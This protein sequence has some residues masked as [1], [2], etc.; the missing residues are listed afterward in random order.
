MLELKCFDDIEKLVMGSA[1]LAGGGGG[2]V[3]EG[4]K[5]GKLA[6]EMGGVKILSIEE[7]PENCKAV[8]IATVGSQIMGRGVVYAVDYNKSVIELLSAVDSKIGV[9]P[10]EVGGL[11]SICPFIPA[12]SL[13]IPVIDAPC[14]GR[15]HPTVL[16]GS[17]GLNRVKS[18]IS[19]QAYS[20]RS[21]AVYG[22]V[23]GSL[24]E[25]SKI[26]RIIASE[27]GAVAVARNPV[28]LEYLKEK[29]APGA[30]EQAYKIGE[31]FI[32]SM[33]NPLE[34]TYRIADLMSG[35]VIE[36]V[37]LNSVKIT[38]KKGFDVGFAK[39][40][41]SEHKIE[42]S[43]IN[44][45]VTLEVDGIRKATFPDL[46]TMIDASNGNP[47]LSMDL[48]RGLKVHIVIVDRKKLKLGYGL[49]VKESYDIIEVLLG[50]KILDYIRDVFIR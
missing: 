42:V 50:K 29:G 40:V 24:S 14:D 25:A 32:N 11:N 13:G 5:I 1:I 23:K 46:I 10:C 22:V 49:R 19:I 38:S 35:V 48:K 47:V 6:V 31:E 4:L 12:V 43:F 2:C 41:S 20:T 9:I 7:A 37:V 36:N 44:E 30:L 39:G 18:Y 26:I 21:G 16:M 27:Y 33:D 28:S 8:T 15:A 45:Y 17:M 3:Y 34:A